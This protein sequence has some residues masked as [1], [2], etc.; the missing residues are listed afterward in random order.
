MSASIRR[1]TVRSAKTAMSAMPS[2]SRMVLAT[3]TAFRRRRLR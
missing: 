2:T 3:V 1:V